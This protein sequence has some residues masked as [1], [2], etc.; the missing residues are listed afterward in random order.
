M[1]VQRTINPKASRKL[2]LKDFLLTFVYKSKHDKKPH[3]EL[4]SET[5]KR[6][7]MNAK[8]P[9]IALCGPPPELKKD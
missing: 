2:K 9:W 3:T 6:L 5:K 8:A 1:E 4:S 7:A